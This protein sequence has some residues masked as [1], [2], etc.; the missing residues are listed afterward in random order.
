MLLMAVVI[1]RWL[2]YTI[3]RCGGDRWRFPLNVCCLLLFV[4]MY[5]A[6]VIGSSTMSE[7]LTLQALA[8][9]AFCSLRSL[10]AISTLRTQISLV[11]QTPT[12][13]SQ[14]PQ[15][16]TNLHQAAISLTSVPP[17]ESADNQS[18]PS[19][20]SQQS[21]YASAIVNPLS[22]QTHSSQRDRLP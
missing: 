15:E 11:G 19:S 3:Y 13:Q 18:Q 5:I 9:I 4:M 2:H 7:V 17:E 21:A 12:F 14:P 20:Y 8:A 6:A 16:S 22:S 1:S 10:K